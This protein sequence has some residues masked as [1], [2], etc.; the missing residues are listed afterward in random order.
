MQAFL[1]IVI[2]IGFA[3]LIR[4]REG[5]VDWRIVSVGLV[6]QFLLATLFLRV[7]WVSE[8]LL[9]ANYAVVA[10]ESATTAGTSFLFGYLGGGAVPFAVEDPNV[11]YLFAF[12]VLPQVIVFSVLVAILWYWRVLPTIVRLLGSALRRAMQVSGIVGTAGSASLFLGWWKRH[13]W[14]API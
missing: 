14:Y 8:A 6:A 1:G 11:M 9:L 5:Q 2:L 10:I 7:A 12:R 13:W 3:W 4:E